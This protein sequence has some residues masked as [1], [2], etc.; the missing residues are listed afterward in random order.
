MNV[1]ERIKHFMAERGWTDY[2][3]GIESGLSRS[4]VSNMFKRYNSPS[5]PTLECIC[6]AFGITM[7]QFFAEADEPVILTE[8]QKVL[9][10]RWNTLTE[11]QKE[12][13][14]EL[15]DTM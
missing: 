4:T 8:D 2:R 10:S 1:Q 15:M 7:S 3:L 11:K 13:L 12:L 14:L 5:I 9:L 6:Q